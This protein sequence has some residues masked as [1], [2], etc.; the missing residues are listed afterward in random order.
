MKTV[1]FN[2]VNHCPL[3]PSE[4]DYKHHQGSAAEL[5]AMYIAADT[6]FEQTAARIFGIRDYIPDAELLLGDGTGELHDRAIALRHA[7][8]LAAR[9]DAEPS[10][11]GQY[12]GI[13]VGVYEIQPAHSSSLPEH[14]VEIANE[15]YTHFAL[16][17]FRK[18]EAYKHNAALAYDITN[19]LQLELGI[20][21]VLTSDA[22]DG[23]AF[24]AM[25]Q[26]GE[27]LQG[28]TISDDR[29]IAWIVARE[30]DLVGLATRTRNALPAYVPRIVESHKTTA[31]GVVDNLSLE[32]AAELLLGRLSTYRV[33]TTDPYVEGIYNTRKNRMGLGGSAMA[34]PRVIALSLPVNCRPNVTHEL[35]HADG[36]CTYS[37]YDGPNGPTLALTGQ[38]TVSYESQEG[39]STFPVDSIEGITEVMSRKT[40]M[41]LGWNDVSS[42]YDPQVGRFGQMAHRYPTL[43]KFALAVNY[44]GIGSKVDLARLRQ[45]NDIFTAGIASDSRLKPASY[46]V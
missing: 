31:S 3:V 22:S 6:E 5:Q 12:L 8:S 7:A 41:A 21:N 46:N 33:D 18:L 24:Q 15:E 13:R 44:R 20:E 27:K 10:T 19:V 14:T 43:T 40:T 32:G 34:V 4:D 9:N 35:S 16:Q 25:E 30:V 29:L 37:I 11:L 1:V 28:T 38:Q 42:G 26:L 17:G 36:S 39:G 45:Y 23:E 2:D